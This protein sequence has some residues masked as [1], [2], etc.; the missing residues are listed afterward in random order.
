MRLEPALRKVYN[1]VTS[2]AAHSKRSRT[3]IVLHWIYVDVTVHPVITSGTFLVYA[4]IANF[5]IL[6]AINLCCAAPLLL[7][8]A[9]VVQS[10]KS[11]AKSV[12]IRRRLLDLFILWE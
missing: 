2:V 3:L 6:F 9:R 8:H 11:G 10:L 12:R 7:R 1:F 5:A 4:L